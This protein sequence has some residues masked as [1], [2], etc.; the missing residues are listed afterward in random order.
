MTGFILTL[1]AEREIT[2]IEKYFIKDDLQD[3]FLYVGKNNPNRYF[4]ETI[5]HEI[6]SFSSL[7]NIEE[8]KQGL[9]KLKNDIDNQSFDKIKRPICKRIRRLLIYN[10]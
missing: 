10:N 6:S 8:V 1:A 4:D 9:S 5:R 7:T 2:D 3:C